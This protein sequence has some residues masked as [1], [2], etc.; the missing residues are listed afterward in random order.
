MLPELRTI[1]I[2]CCVCGKKKRG[3]VEELPRFG[4]EVTAIA[5]AAGWDTGT[6][7]KHSR[8]L[9]FC[10]KR[11]EAAAVTKDGKYYRKNI[12]TLTEEAGDAE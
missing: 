9:I 1:T 11:C 3:E 2:R 10:S 4:F 5:R 12:P 8:T 6:D 7:F